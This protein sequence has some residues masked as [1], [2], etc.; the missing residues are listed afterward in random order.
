MYRE[1]I[2]VK[3]NSLHFPFF[4]NASDSHNKIHNKKSRSPRPPRRAQTSGHSWY[5]VFIFTF[6][7]MFLFHSVSLSVFVYLYVLFSFRFVNSWS[8]RIQSQV[9]WTYHTNHS[10]YGSGDDAGVVVVFCAILPRLHP[11]FI[12]RIC[13]CYISGKFSHF[14]ALYICIEHW[15]HPSV[16]TL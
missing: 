11:I 7:F 5:G 4:V 10:C 6:K 1:D 15:K 9:L 16:R 14:S 12:F 3:H 13:L 2:N 8:I